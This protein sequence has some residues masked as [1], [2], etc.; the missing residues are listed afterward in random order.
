MFALVSN[1]KNLDIISLQTGQV[2]G[3]LGEPIINPDK[4]EIMAFFVYSGWLKH[5]QSVLLTRDVRELAQNAVLID[6]FEEIEDAGE[7]VRLKEV[8]EGNFKLLGIQVVNESGLK[9]GRVEDYTFDLASY[10]IS[11][12]YVKQSI[13]RNF[14][15]N[16]LIIDRNQ[17]IDITPKKIVVRDATVKKPL[18]VPTA[19]PLPTK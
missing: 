16:N 13:M 12:L 17:I 8:L 3:R 19:P 15:L 1:A 7:I 6:S 9:L 14:L 11:K 4:L 18:T 5:Q 2:V 10:K